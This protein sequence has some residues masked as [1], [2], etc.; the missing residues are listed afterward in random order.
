MAEVEEREKKLQQFK[1]DIRA[2]CIS[3]AENFLS[4]DNL[5]D[6]YQ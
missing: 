6:D 4:I 5:I 2:F 1:A 3:A